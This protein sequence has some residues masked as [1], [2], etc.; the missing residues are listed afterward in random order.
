MKSHKSLCLLTLLILSLYATALG[1]KHGVLDDEDKWQP[2]KN[3]T[4]PYIKV[5]GEFSV[6]YYN[7]WTSSHLWL[8]KVLKGDT[9]GHYYDNFYY[10]LAL[11]AKDGGVTKK[12][13]AIVLERR[14]EYYRNLTSFTPL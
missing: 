14:Y 10:R 4:D 9:R 8:E 6:Y 13:Q 3:I 11:E 12:Y 1:G 5:L 2:I 7:N